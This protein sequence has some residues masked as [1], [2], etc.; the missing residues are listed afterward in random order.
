[1]ISFKLSDEQRALLVDDNE[2]DHP[3]SEPRTN[4]VLVK[5]ANKR[6]SFHALPA[7]EAYNPD[8]LAA[9]FD[10][11]LAP[12]K[13]GRKAKKATN[14]RAVSFKTVQMANDAG[15]QDDTA[16]AEISLKP[17]ALEAQ[18]GQETTE[19]PQAQPP[20]KFVVAPGQSVNLFEERQEYSEKE[21]LIVWGAGIVLGVAACYLLFKLDGLFAKAS[22]LAPVSS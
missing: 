5:D 8:A 2:T 14:P 13:A 15:D 11:A 1:M 4:R 17:A 10:P 16:R 21:I 22:T 20:Q 12:K 18:E 6:P 19:P 7:A 3:E 9:Q